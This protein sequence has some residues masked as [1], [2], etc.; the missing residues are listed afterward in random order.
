MRRLQQIGWLNQQ[1][2]FEMGPFEASS[3]RWNPQDVVF[4]AK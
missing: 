3:I 1:G 4:S 2:V